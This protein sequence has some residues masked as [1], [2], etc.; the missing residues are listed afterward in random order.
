MSRCSILKHFYNKVKHVK[1]PNSPVPQIQHYLMSL[2][3]QFPATIPI[4]DVARLWGICK[5][6]SWSPA[7]YD[8]VPEVLSQRMFQVRSNVTLS[9]VLSVLIGLSKD[10]VRFQASEP[11]V[12]S[13]IEV[14]FRDIDRVAPDS[15]L[16]VA[17]L[18]IFETYHSVIPVQYAETFFRWL[19]RKY[20]PLSP[21]SIAV[22]SRSQWL[23]ILFLVAKFRLEP[24][25]QEYAATVISRHVIHHSSIA[26]SPS[27]SSP[28]SS[29]PLFLR[30][31]FVQCVRFKL[32]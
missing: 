25:Q 15:A 12:L 19:H 14:L 20:I 3:K 29:P 22:L 1:E 21:E 7:L 2:D 24:I 17:V 23:H 16:L 27:S 6:P 5:H 30:P 4:L 8:T 32:L 31:I 10:D 26:L 9:E 18:N 13:C 28:S 11:I